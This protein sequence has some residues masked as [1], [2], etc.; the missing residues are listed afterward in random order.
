MEKEALIPS[1]TSQKLNQIDK[2]LNLYACILITVLLTAL[3]VIAYYNIAYDARNCRLDVTIRSMDFTV[4]NM[5]ETRLSVKWDLLIRIA[6]ENPVCFLCRNGDYKVNI[7]YNGVTIATSPI[8]S[9]IWAALMLKVSL[10]A[11]EGDMDGAIMKNIVE[12]IKAR[13]EVR[14]GS[15]MLFSDGRDGTSGKMN[16]ACDEATLRFKPGS[17]RDATLVETLRECPYQP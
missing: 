6:P 14:F 7:S 16:Y 11:S 1:P 3:V 5:T 13:G 2:L 9:Y 15:G 17:Q 4:L 8:E 12:D 10:I